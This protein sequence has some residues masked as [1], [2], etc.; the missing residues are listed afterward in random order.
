M[1]HAS[2]AEAAFK[3]KNTDNAAAAV[4]ELGATCSTCHTKYRDKSDTGYVIRK[5][6][7]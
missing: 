6:G 3:A 5:G 1:K 7:S 2:S 4:K